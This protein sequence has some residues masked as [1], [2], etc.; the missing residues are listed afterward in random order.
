MSTIVAY[1]EMV[2]E[3]GELTEK[4]YQGTFWDDGTWGFIK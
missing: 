4:R 1:G 3:D 2:G